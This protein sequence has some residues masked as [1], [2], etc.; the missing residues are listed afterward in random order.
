M[1]GVYD[2]S[3]ILISGRNPNTSLALANNCDSTLG[4]RWG[5]HCDFTCNCKGNTRCLNTGFC[6]HGCR[7][8]WERSTEH[9]PCFKRYDGIGRK[10]QPRIENLNHGIWNTSRPRRNASISPNNFRGGEKRGVDFLVSFS[11]V[12]KIKCKSLQS[13]VEVSWTVKSPIQLTMSHVFIRYQANFLSRPRYLKADI[14]LMGYSQPVSQ[15]F[16]L[17]FLPHTGEQVYFKEFKSP[18][19]LDG[20]RLSFLINGSGSCFDKQGTGVVVLHGAPVCPYRRWGLRCENHCECPCEIP[21][22][23]PITGSCSHRLTFCS[24][25]KYGRQC[26]KLCSPACGNTAVRQSARL[27]QRTSRFECHVVSGFCRVCKSLNQTGSECNGTMN[28]SEL[29]AIRSSCENES[30]IRKPMVMRAQLDRKHNHSV[31]AITVQKNWRGRIALFAGIAF[32]AVF[33]L[34]FVV[35][36]ICV[37]FWARKKLRNYMSKLERQRIMRTSIKSWSELRDEFNATHKVS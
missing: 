36:V 24:K 6:P 19:L 4:Q 7:F 34:G 26:E 32:I 27:Y 3:S 14:M 16:Q 10:V 35:Y 31:A 22:C 21:E 1:S 15:V 25:G 2:S 28:I 20:L 5:S 23:H 12:S 18:T 8:G 30:K 13:F 33:I 17:H 37:R 9:S 11:F 29:R